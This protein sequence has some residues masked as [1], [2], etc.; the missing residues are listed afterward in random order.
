M[1]EKKIVQ[2]LQLPEI[3]IAGTYKETWKY[4]FEK[5]N[6]LHRGSNVHLIFEELPFK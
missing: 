4:I 3:M 1:D 2:F 5:L 6:S